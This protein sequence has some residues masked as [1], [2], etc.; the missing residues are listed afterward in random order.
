MYI[1]NAFFSK[2]NGRR[3]GQKIMEYGR[4]IEEGTAV[5]FALPFRETKAAIW[6]FTSSFFVTEEPLTTSSGWEEMVAEKIV[7]H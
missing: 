3:V 5:I 4:R 7:T 6:E 2:G 1:I